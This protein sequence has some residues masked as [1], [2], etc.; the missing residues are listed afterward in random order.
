MSDCPQEEEKIEEGWVD[1]QAENAN[2]AEIQSSESSSRGHKSKADTQSAEPATMNELSKPTTSNTKRSFFRKPFL[3]M[4][5]HMS[6]QISA[7]NLPSL[8]TTDSSVHASHLSNP[9]SS[10]SSTA[11]GTPTTEVPPSNAQSSLNSYLESLKLTDG[12]AVSELKATPPI[13]PRTLSDDGNEHVPSEASPIKHPATRGNSLSLNQGAAP[14]RG[15]PVSNPKGKLVV[16]VSGARGLKPSFDPYAVCVFEWIESIAH[17]HKSD[18][19]VEDG[20][21]RGRESSTSSMPIKRSGGELGRAM[22]IRMK[23]R[24]SSATSLSDQKDLKITKE[25]TD[26]Q[27]DHQVV[28]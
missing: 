8:V 28:L 17:G 21:P 4:P 20:D 10:A 26:P 27:W 25:V 5:L 18:D 9:T 12:M 15:A 1:T 11:P 24:Q 6:K 7:S 23:S 2:G 13:T 3:S 16:T 19:A 14:T 22:A